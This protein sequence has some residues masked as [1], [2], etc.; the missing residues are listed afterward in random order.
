MGPRGSQ[1]SGGQKQRLAIAK[2]LLRHPKILSVNQLTSLFSKQLCLFL[3][4]SFSLSL[5]DEATS[6]LDS[7]SEML[8]QRALDAASRGRTTIAVAHRLSS[9]AHADCIYVFESGAIVEYGDHDALMKKRGKYWGFVQLQS[10]D[11]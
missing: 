4:N 10:L 9:I 11:Q 6:A 5:L 8:V 2:A 3:T 1:V 7:E